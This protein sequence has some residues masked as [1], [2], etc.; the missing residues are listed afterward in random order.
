M[1]KSMSGWSAGRWSGGWRGW[2]Y[3][4]GTEHVIQKIAQSYEIENGSYNA[5]SYYQFGVYR[6][7]EQWPRFGADM[8][9]SDDRVRPGKTDVEHSLTERFWNVVRVYYLGL[10]RLVGHK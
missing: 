1:K 7:G 6:P 9:E 8:R 5:G 3:G 4:D 2:N 10:L